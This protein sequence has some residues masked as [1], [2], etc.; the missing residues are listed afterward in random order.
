VGRSCFVLLCF[1]AL[2]S[3]AKAESGIASFSYG[4][5]GHPWRAN[6]RASHATVWKPCQS[7]LWRSLNYL[8]HSG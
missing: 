6:M 4:N 3:Q 2:I 5:R 7:D 1:A 8:S